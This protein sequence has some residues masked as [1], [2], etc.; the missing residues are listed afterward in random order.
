MSH[1]RSRGKQTGLA[2]WHWAVI[3]IGKPAGPQADL[4]FLGQVW[5]ELLRLGLTWAY[6]KDFK[7]AQIGP[8]GLGLE[9]NK[10]N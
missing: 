3:G 4:C 7:W 6:K 10:K 5:P 8:L 1:G 9:P 2:W